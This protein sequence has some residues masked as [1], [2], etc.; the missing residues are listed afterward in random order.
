MSFLY[1]NGVHPS[2]V[3]QHEEQVQHAHSTHTHGENDFFS[4][5]LNIPEKDFPVDVTFPRVT[6]AVV[7]SKEA[8]VKY[9]AAKVVN[10]KKAA[11]PKATTT[12]SLG[13]KR[14]FKVES[15]EKPAA[16]PKRGAAAKKNAK[17]E[18]KLKEEQFDDE[19]D[20]FEEG[21]TE[22]KQKRQRRLLKNREAAQ[23]FRQRQKAYIQDLEKKVA[24][25]NAETTQFR[26]KVDLLTTE[27]KLVRE[28]MNYMRSFLSQI[29]MP[30]FNGGAVAPGATAPKSLVMPEIAH[31]LPQSE[32][33]PQP[34]Q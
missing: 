33:Q 15:E 16:K 4:L 5:Y 2:S 10:A 17:E 20:K 11:T 21:D 24:K 6:A 30:N 32:P 28:Q 31:L 25:L 19:D 13:R 34:Q 14:K 23:L 8:P 27:N 22:S 3:V 1:A 9:S 26:S 29:M 12:A 7:E 18:A